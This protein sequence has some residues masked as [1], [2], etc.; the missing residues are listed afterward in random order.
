[1]SESDFQKK[2]CELLKKHNTSATKLA[3]KIGTNKSTLF[4]WSVGVR[5]QSIDTLKKIADI[6]EIELYDLLFGTRD[7]FSQKPQEADHVFLE[8]MIKKLE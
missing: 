1:M 4:N 3:S 7:P 6:F 5:P 8:I 2:F